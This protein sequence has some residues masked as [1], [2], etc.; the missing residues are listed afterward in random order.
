M[1]ETTIQRH[2]PVEV[3]QQADSIRTTAE[4]AKAALASEELTAFLTGVD[5]VIWTGSGDCY[6]VGS[7]ISAF[8]E[9][10]AGIPATWLEAYDF[11]Q[12]TPNLD[13]NS[14]VISFS[15]SGKSVYAVE[16]VTKARMQGARTLAVANKPDSRLQEVAHRAILTQAGDSFTFPTKTTT[17]A[18]LIG[19]LLAQRVG[20]LRGWKP[21]NR[22]PSPDAIAAS[23]SDGVRQA[24]SDMSLFVSGLNRA[25]RVLVVGSGLGRTA[26]LIGAAKL[27]ET[28]QMPTTSCNCEEFLH[29]QGFGAMAQDAVIAIHDGNL[30]SRLAIEYAV[31]QGCHTIVVTH[32]DAASLPE[33]AKVIRLPA[34]GDPVLQLFGSIGAVQAIA[35]AV[36]QE[37]GTNPDI[38]ADVDLD[39]VIGLLYTDPV[40]GWNESAAR[41]IVHEP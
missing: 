20:E 2:F 36:S 24:S 13:E 16:A 34:S 21:A 22:G 29:L 7:A 8:F 39:Y 10:Q 4:S 17:T 31:N 9:E 30:R 11:V 28:C 25:R 18:L 3:N 1:S 41:G 6:F 33:N 35:A 37:R 19:L 23:L 26:A 15:S 14:L 40:D 32:N 27:I 12:T 5:R 38:P